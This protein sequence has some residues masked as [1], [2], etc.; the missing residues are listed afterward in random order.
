MQ[1]VPLSM[2]QKNKEIAGIKL[3]DQELNLLLRL[4]QDGAVKP[5]SISTKH[6]GEQFFLFTPTP[7]GAALAPTKREIYERAMAIVAAV[8]QGQFLPKQY[9]IRSPGAVLYTLKSNLKLGRGTTEATQQYRKLV[10]LRIARLLD[11]GN[12][13]SELQIID[14]PENR[15]AL[16][17]AYNLVNAGV[18]SGAEVDQAARDALQQEYTFVESLVSSG[19]LQRR[20]NVPLTH[21]QQLEIENLFLK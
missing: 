15:E 13:F 21:E 8:R 20:Y 1:G 6:S 16:E 18:T 4:A 7:L 12:G 10:H 11:V 2:I 5:P 17:M 19:E 3:T 14:T 9:A